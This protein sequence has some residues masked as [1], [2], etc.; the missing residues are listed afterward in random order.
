M[1]GN[2]GRHK[3]STRLMARI[4][5]FTPNPMFEQNSNRTSQK[6]K[7]AGLAVTSNK[8]RPW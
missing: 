3:S 6:L 4:V 7:R 8:S 5:A 1:A 2:F